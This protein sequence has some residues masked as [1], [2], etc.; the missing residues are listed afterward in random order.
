MKKW[1]KKKTKR[2]PRSALYYALLALV[3]SIFCYYVA[4]TLVSVEVYKKLRTPQK[5]SEQ[6]KPSRIA[7]T[8]E[9]PPQ[10]LLVG[11]VIR[12]DKELVVYASSFTLCKGCGSL[13]LWYTQSKNKSVFTLEAK[14]KSPRRF[15]FRRLDSTLCLVALLTV[16]LV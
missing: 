9:V 8:L 5:Q 13:C 14:N 1:K 11:E 15:C 16:P 10:V 3:V 4:Q 7:P 12:S 2:L 6:E